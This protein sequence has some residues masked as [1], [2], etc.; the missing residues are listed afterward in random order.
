MRLFVERAFDNLLGG[1]YRQ[2]CEFAAELFDSGASLALDIGFRAAALRFD[3]LPNLR[4][5]FLAEAV[6]NL[7]RG[8]DELLTFCAGGFELRC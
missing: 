1:G 5:L 6:G 3:L 8:R 4:G 7:T 2:A